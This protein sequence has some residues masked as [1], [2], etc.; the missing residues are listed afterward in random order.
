MRNCKNINMFRDLRSTKL[1]YVNLTCCD[2][3]NPLVER[4]V[5]A[6]RP[7]TSIRKM[8]VIDNY[9]LEMNSLGNLF[10]LKKIKAIAEE[11]GTIVFPEVREKDK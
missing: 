2:L 3:T 10:R 1:E 9:E 5:C 4:I 7:L 6:I 11:D 8:V